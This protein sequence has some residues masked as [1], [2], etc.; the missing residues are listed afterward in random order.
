MSIWYI[1]ISSILLAVSL[2]LVTI[3]LMQNKRSGISSTFTGMGGTVQQSFWEKNK[4]RSREGIL[5][6]YTKITGAVFV[7]LTLVLNIV[8]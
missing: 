7:V 3:I 4:S 8:K 6:K 2:I 5:E 1:V